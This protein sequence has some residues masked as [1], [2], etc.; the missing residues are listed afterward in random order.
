MNSARL[1]RERTRVPMVLLVAA[2]MVAG[3][4]VT[5]AAPSWAAP[6]EATPPTIVPQPQEYESSGVTRPLGS[7][8]R[9]TDPGDDAALGVI[10]DALESRGVSVTVV[11]EAAAGGSDLIRI[12][13]AARPDISSSLHGVDAP[14]ADESYALAITNDAITVAG[15]DGA[16][17]YYGAQTLQ[18]LF[19]GSGAET[20][21][22]E[23]RIAD[24]PA[25]PLRGSIEGFYGAP[26][27]HEQRLDQLRF[28]GT[29]KMN[30]Y[31]YAPK[32][33]E[34]HRSRWREPYPADKLAELGELVSAA[35]SNH[36]R[37]TFALSPGE[38]IC[39]SRQSDRDAILAKFDA[40]YELGVRSFSIPLDDISYQRWNCTEDAAAYG[41]AGSANAGAAQVD[42]LNHVQTQWVEQ[43]PDVRALQ[44]VPTEY[45]DTRRTAYKQKFVDGLDADVV[46]M[47]T[48]TAVVPPSI[49]R[50]DAAAAASAWGRQVFLWDNYPVNDF[51][52]TTGRLLMGAYD[53]REH[54]LS[55]SLLGIVSNPMNQASASKPAIAGIAAFSWNDQD[56][57]PSQVRSWTLAQMAGGDAATTAALEVFADVNSAA[58]TFSST[59][60]LP[61]A[62]RLA[63]LVDAAAPDFDGA[64]LDDLD[65]YAQQLTDGPALIREHVA[66]TLFLEETG[67][68]LDA[69]RLWGEALGASIAAIRAHELGDDDEAEALIADSVEAVRAAQ[70][71]RI[72]DQRN[73]WSANSTPTPRIG[74]GV[75]DSLIAK[76][77]VLA[78][79]SS[80]NWALG[81]PSV[82]STGVEPGTTF[83]PQLAVD[84][85]STTRFASDYDDA[86]SITVQL[87][88]TVMVSEVVLKWEAA[89][90]ARYIVQL[91]TDGTI[92]HDI[93]VDESTCATERIMSDTAMP[94]NFVRM[95]GVERATQ[96]AYS[97]WELEVY[98]VP[99]DV[100]PTLTA[101]APAANAGESVTVT[102]RGFAPY[103]PVIIAFDEE[104]GVEAVELRANEAGRATGAVAI[105]ADANPA[106]GT[107]RARGATS[108]REA[109]TPFTILGGAAFDMTVVA[110]TRCVAGKALV[111]VKASSDADAPVA[112]EIESAYG[113]RAFASVAP[114]KNAVHAFTTRQ[115]SIDAGSVTVEATAVI[116]GD[117]VK[118]EVVSA[119]DAAAC[120]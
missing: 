62:P 55:D 95:Q 81:S 22:T 116:E 17:V 78:G 107:L 47:W 9:V 90:A 49:S 105:P 108:D 28:Y 54:G 97:L 26:W 5:S 48:G 21:A 18:Q 73:T 35:A 63:A 53:K 70:A 92:W 75:L 60:W 64:S 115:P 65:A 24:A 111:M 25:M 27:T 82:V 8:V 66:D 87:T 14:T 85:N 106:A 77:Q 58:P 37:F 51:S 89:C 80:Q 40:L 117:P 98:G 112:L 110:S 34:Y 45:S 57:D 68:W 50:A 44:M 99:V 12:G 114:G 91:S 72:T 6:A 100:A 16:G 94:V 38:S 119:Y 79:A 4:A 41:P 120:G 29:V 56:Y 71:V 10:S 86:A 33:D 31:I 32:D 20:S 103:E 42:L 109:T 11:D 96:W 39:F 67:P 76:L 1:I 104:T 93:P 13:D 19:S 7:A 59:M 61:Q 113:T 74:D 101:S 43:T 46:I 102:A 83:R 36:V 15:A 52:Q 23:A 88:R 69:S 3:L 118:V 2:T 84:G 30:T